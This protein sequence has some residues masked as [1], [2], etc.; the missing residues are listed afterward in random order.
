MTI[1]IFDGIGKEEIGRG[2]TR[3]I[4]SSLYVCMYIWGQDIDELKITGA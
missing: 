2:V 4:V 3:V 1:D